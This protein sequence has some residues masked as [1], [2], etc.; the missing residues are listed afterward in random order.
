MRNEQGKMEKALF[1]IQSHYEETKR[2]T[3][4]QKSQLHEIQTD[5]TLKIDETKNI[6]KRPTEEYL[7]TIEKLQDQICKIEAYACFEDG[8]LKLVIIRKILYCLYCTCIKF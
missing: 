3:L 7:R 5:T 2:N 4:Q 8:K 6:F 1:H